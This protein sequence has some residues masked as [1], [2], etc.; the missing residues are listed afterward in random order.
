MAA[1]TARLLLTPSL[2]DYVEVSDEA[3]VIDIRAPERLVGKTLAE[4]EIRKLHGVIMLAIEKAAREGK[5]RR[6]ILVP[7]PDEVIENQDIL[8]LF[9]PNQRLKQ[10]E[11]EVSG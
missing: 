5:E 7:G 6:T 4:T 1:R 8:V 3:G 11:R 10:I 9:G 2:L